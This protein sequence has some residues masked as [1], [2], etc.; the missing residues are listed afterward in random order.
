LSATNAGMQAFLNY[1]QD[2]LKYI[3]ELESKRL[4]DL[5][6]ARAAIFKYALPATIIDAAAGAFGTLLTGNILIL[7]PTALFVILVYILAEAIDAKKYAER[8]DIMQQTT[9]SLYEVSLREIEL[10]KR[11]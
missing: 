7:L 2:K 8:M 4:E 1:K 11:L 5:K 9:A 3:A 10:L 6:D